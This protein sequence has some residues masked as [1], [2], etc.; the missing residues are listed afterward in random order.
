MFIKT[1]QSSVHSDDTGTRPLTRARCTGMRALRYSIRVFIK[2]T[3]SSAHSGDSGHV[4][5]AARAC[6]QFAK[7]DQTNEFVQLSTHKR[8][9]R[10]AAHSS[11]SEHGHWL[12]LVARAC[13]LCAI[14]SECLLRL[15]R[16]LHTTVTATRPLAWTRCTCM[17]AVCK[18]RPDKRVCA[19]VDPQGVAS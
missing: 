9:P 6:M 2:T 18:T 3:P 8:W 11:D 7:R 4:W 14:V 16:H 5:L 17:R 1:T 15:H 19:T 13:M 10:E 12:A